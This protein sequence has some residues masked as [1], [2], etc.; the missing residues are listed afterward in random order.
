LAST[1][2][3]WLYDYKV[4]QQLDIRRYNCYSWLTIAITGWGFPTM[5]V[6]QNGWFTMANLIKMNDLGYPQFR[7]KPPYV[8]GNY[9]I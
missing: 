4:Y 2:P 7:K 8:I 6:P 9:M 5:G 1:W 3:G